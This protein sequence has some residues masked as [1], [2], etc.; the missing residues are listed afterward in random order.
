MI[1]WLSFVVVV[2]GRRA[3]LLLFVARCALLLIA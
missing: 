2:V 3:S 1:R